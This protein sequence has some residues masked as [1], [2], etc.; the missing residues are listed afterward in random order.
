[1]CQ[2]LNTFYQFCGCTGAKY[3]QKCP[4]PS[5]TCELLLARPTPVKLQC[6]CQKHSPQTFKSRLKSERERK[7]ID[8]EYQKIVLCESQRLLEKD[9]AALQRREEEI[10]ALKY[11]EFLAKDRRKAEEYKSRKAKKK[12]GLKPGIREKSDGICEIM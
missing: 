10:D 7:R 12:A 11:E 2:S 1:M 9:R 5:S 3:E 6:Y 4:E 8:K